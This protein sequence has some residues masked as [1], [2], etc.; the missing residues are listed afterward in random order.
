[1]ARRVD[2][3][4]A[5]IRA[6]EVGVTGVQERQQLPKLLLI[7]ERQMDD[8]V[9]GEPARAAVGGKG[10]QTLQIKRQRVRISAAGGRYWRTQRAV[11][12]FY[13]EARN[14]VIAAIGDVRKCAP[15][16]DGDCVALYLLSEGRYQSTAR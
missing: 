15:R 10:G 12:R 13:D 7:D 6:G 11:R 5:G 3:R 2:R 16:A 9:R 14:G 1:M 8:V 4:R